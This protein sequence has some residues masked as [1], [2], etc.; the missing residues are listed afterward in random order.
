[1]RSF[2]SVVDEAR[3]V[4]SPAETVVRYL[5]D[6][7]AQVA[8]RPVSETADEQFEQAL[9]DRH[10]PLIDLALARWCCHLPTGRA[11]L[12]AHPGNSTHD[13]AV[14]LSLLSNVT[15]GSIF[16]STGPTAFFGDCPLDWFPS[17]TDEE[18]TTLFKNPSLNNQFFEAFFNGGPVWICLSEPQR[19]TALCAL[20]DNPRMS[21]PSD[22]S[23]ADG[24]A[25]FS[26][27][28]VF[29]AAW[30]M[31]ATAPNTKAW[32]FALGWLFDVLLPIGHGIDDPLIFAARWTP[33]DDEGI[34]HGA[35]SP[36]QS[37]RKGLARLA[38]AKSGRRVDEFLAS[39]DPALRAAVYASRSLDA[40]Q[41]ATAT[42]RDGP[43]GFGEMVRNESL[44]RDEEHRE[45]LRSASWAVVNADPHSD[46]L[47][48]NLFTG[49][50]DRMEREHPSWFGDVVTSD[51]DDLDVPA[52][53]GDMHRVLEALAGSNTNV[54][55][56]QVGAAIQTLNRRLGWV[57]WFSLGA[58]LATVGHRL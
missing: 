12:N 4:V 23:F 37:V 10:D 9:L 45:A 33:D 55:L 3:L 22:Q 40:D 7:G 26:H 13:L 43:M 38:L 48:H 30:K 36:F 21:T 15:A 20:T 6:R 1:M 35:L 47:P 16:M 39:E 53:R 34:K 29:E 25:E 54:G 11:L 2:N 17:A 50:W 49:M 19:L 24:Y 41:I 14:R 52:T 31:A 32:A 8:K 58:L 51:L 46:L 18:L 44:W 27:N 57:W 5:E 42:K 28:K 56:Q